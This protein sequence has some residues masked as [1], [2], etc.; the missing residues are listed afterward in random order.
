MLP[1]IANKNK[2]KKL[3]N[4]IRKSKIDIIKLRIK[5]KMK[6]RRIR[7][8]KMMMKKNKRMILNSYFRDLK[9]SSSKLKGLKIIN[10]KNLI[11]I[12]RVQ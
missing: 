8:N 5:M 2:R 3:L 1:K 4:M 11:I 9:R 10:R 7:K 6:K 12:E